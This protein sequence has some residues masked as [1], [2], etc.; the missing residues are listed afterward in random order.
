MYAGPASGSTPTFG[1][2]PPLWHENDAATGEPFT[3]SPTSGSRPRLMI[4]TFTGQ[5]A[6]YGSPL[7]SPSCLMA[8]TRPL[9]NLRIPVEPSTPRHAVLTPAALRSPSLPVP[10]AYS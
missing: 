8:K 3:P 10:V 6:R 5:P 7:A 2:A 1:P 9:A 4:P